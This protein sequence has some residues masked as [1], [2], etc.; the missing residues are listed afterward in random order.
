MGSATVFSSSPVQFVNV[1]ASLCLA[2]NIVACAMQ[3]VSSRLQDLE[4]LQ[5]KQ[6]RGLAIDIGSDLDEL[7][8]SLQVSRLYQMQNV[9]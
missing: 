1:T 5:S 3:D 8:D 4:D 7:N 6:L 2:L 9:L